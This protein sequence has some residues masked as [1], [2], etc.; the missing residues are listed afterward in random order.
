ME[1]Y[2]GNAVYDYLWN[3]AEKG[4]FFFTS[5]DKWVMVYGGPDARPLLL[6]VVTE[7]ELLI[8]LTMEEITIL[9]LVRR[10]A[11]LAELPLSFIRFRPDRKFERAVYLEETPY[12]REK[13][14][15]GDLGLILP[16]QLK[17]RFRWFGVPVRSGGASK[18]INDRA[19]SPYHEWQR[20]NLG[21]DLVASDIDLFRFQDGR[22]SGILELK[23]SRIPLQDWTPYENDR[24]NYAL[25]WALAERAG[26]LFH[27]VYNYRR[28]QPFLD[29]VR[30]LKIFRVDFEGEPFYRLLGYES[31]EEFCDN[32]RSLTA[33]D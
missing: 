33:H 27:A 30:R 22:I 15:R 10:L 31:I 2:T 5:R 4:S 14:V 29:D 28:E 9:K 1:Y 13:G 16:E 24:N 20:A 6:T 11:R 32:R 3:N 23:R 17:E 21:S 26:I 12:M 7:G 18:K 8:K 25:L 19:S